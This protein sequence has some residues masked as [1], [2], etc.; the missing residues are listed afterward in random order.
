M[1]QK[2]GVTSLSGGPP[3]MEGLAAL[4][5]LPRASQQRLDRFS[6]EFEEAQWIEIIAKSLHMDELVTRHSTIMDKFD[7]AQK[8][9]LVVD[10]WGTW[11][12]VEPGTNPGLS[13]SAG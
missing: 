6:D 3:Y 4:L 8:V 1:M 2:A 9:G 5:H 13:L 7:P 11:F 12:A 10:E